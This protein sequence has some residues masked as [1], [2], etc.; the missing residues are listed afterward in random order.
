MKIIMM[1]YWKLGAYAWPTIVKIEYH[2]FTE[3]ND[4]V[5]GPYTTQVEAMA[6]YPKARIGEW[7]EVNA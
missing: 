3:A 2:V 6:A 1:R 5:A 4:D 7:W